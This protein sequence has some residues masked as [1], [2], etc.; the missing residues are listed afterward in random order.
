VNAV[1]A[2]TPRLRGRLHQVAVVVAIPAGVALVISAPTGATKAATAIYAL[3]LAGLF[4]ASAAYHRVN[5]SQRVRARMRTL[6]HAMIFLLIAGTYTAVGALAL[7]GLWR[8]VVLATVWVGALVGIVLKVIRIDGFTRV[9][10]TLYIVLGWIGVAAAP[11]ILSQASVASIVLIACGGLIYTFGAIVLL[12]GRPDP[13]PLVFGY[14]E[15]WH[16]MV[17]AASTCHY[18]AIAVLLRAA[19]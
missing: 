9:G 4:A 14:H 1:P 11:Q 8:V 6:D 17:I 16:A 19:R 7:E 13:F 10:G 18:A 5:W 12:R 2:T 15:V 3:S